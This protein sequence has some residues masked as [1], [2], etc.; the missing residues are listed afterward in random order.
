M[1]ATIYLITNTVNGKKY[2]GFSTLDPSDRLNKHFRDAKNG[3]KTYLCN[4]IRKYGSNFFI[5]ETIDSCSLEEAKESLEAKYIK[6]YKTHYLNGYGYNMTEGGE[7]TIG[8][9]HSDQTK[10]QMSIDRTGK[11]H[12]EATKQLLSDQRKGPNNPNYKRVYS[13]EER[14]KISE[15]LSGSNN[16]RAKKYKVKCPD[17]Q[18]VIVND[19]RGF[20]KENDLNYWSVCAATK[21]GNVYKGYSFEY[22]SE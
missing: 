2:V 18:T 14:A 16:P 17:G 12:T 1:L 15:K 21:R 19:R 10:R 6:K 5:I 7:G 20:C 8:H 4:A 22:Y 11:R 13:E 3:R 9:K